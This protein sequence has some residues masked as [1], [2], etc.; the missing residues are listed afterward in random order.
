MNL[1]TSDEPMIY[2]RVSN[3]CHFASADYLYYS[4]STGTIGT[5][6]RR[7]PLLLRGTRSGIGGMTDS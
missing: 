4:E 6:A 3:E 7:L 5:T 2:R 1:Y